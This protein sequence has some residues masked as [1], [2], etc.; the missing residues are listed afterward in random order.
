MDPDEIE[1]LAEKE[2]ISIVPTFNEQ[3]INLITGDVG[4]FI[5]GLPVNVPLWMA[6]NLKQ[7]QKCKICC[8]D[9][10]EIEILEK[11]KTDEIGNGYLFTK[12]ELCNVKL[13]IL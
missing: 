11:I 9:W 12:T 1:F 7:Q 4:P 8:P 6:L 3:E 10:M 2:L 5:A 13:F